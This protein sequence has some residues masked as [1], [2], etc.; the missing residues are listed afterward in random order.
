MFPSTIY[1]QTFGWVFAQQTFDEGNQFLGLAFSALFLE[2]QLL[3][4]DVLLGLRNKIAIKGI[5][6]AHHLI[7]NQ[8]K[9]SE[10]NRC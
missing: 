4:Q 10:I 7:Q 9:R 3:F 5:F 6:I 8:S 2:I 1:C